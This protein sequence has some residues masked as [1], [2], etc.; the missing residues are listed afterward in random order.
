MRKF[1]FSTLNVLEFLDTCS[2]AGLIWTRLL[3]SSHS[4]IQ[5][6]VEDTPWALIVS[7]WGS[8]H[9]GW[10]EHAMPLRTSAQKR[11]MAHIF[12]AHLVKSQSLYPQSV[13]WGCLQGKVEKRKRKWIIVNKWYNL[14]AL[15]G[16]YCY[17]SPD[18]EE[19]WSTER[20]RTSSKV[21]QLLSGRVKISSW[22]VWLHGVESFSRFYLWELSFLWHDLYHLV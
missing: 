13:E 22:G 8:E 19:N 9:T 21:L 14:H 11:Q 1:P 7:G 2:S 17:N 3:M 4:R 16:R 10:W 15:W 20:L 12:M 18:R 6:E 5:D